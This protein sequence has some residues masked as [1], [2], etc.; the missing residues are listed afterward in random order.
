MKTNK[1]RFLLLAVVYGAILLSATFAMAKPIELSFGLIVPPKHLRYVQA[2]EPWMKMIEEK[3]KGAIKINPYFNMTLSPAAE[4]FDATVSGVADMSECYTF[5]N[6]GRFLATEYL[7]LPETGFKSSLA[8]SRALWHLYKTFPEVRAEYKG[9]K[10][11]FLHSV[12]AAKLMMKKK[13]VRSVEDVKGLKIA[14]SGAIGAKVGRALGFSPVSMPTADIYESQDKGV[15]DGHIRPSELLVSR[16][17]YEV[18]KYI[19]DMDMGHDL[20]YV[21][22]NEKTWNKLTPEVQKAFEEFSGDWAVDFIGK[23][24]DKFDKEA[25]TEV[26]GKGLE[27]ITLTPPEQAK[28]R[29]LLTPVQEQYA[30]ELEAKK[31]PG[32]KI[33]EELKKFLA[34]SK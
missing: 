2:L 13:A 15:I 27:L 24:Q 5:G 4:M 10:V 18:T 32:K 26:I 12:P 7:M 28:W 30:A 6:P 23:A 3:S 1:I 33:A 21:A 31:L 17:F 14:A 8:A 19:V 9:V 11:L 20:F 29:K 16:R 34:T 22:M 25:E